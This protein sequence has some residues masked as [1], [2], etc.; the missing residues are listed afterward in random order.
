MTDLEKVAQ[1]AADRAVRGH[2]E[3]V[4]EAVEAGI[5]NSLT[6]LGL[7]AAHPMESQRDM[8]FLRATRKAAGSVKSKALLTAVGIAVAGF[9]ALLLHKLTTL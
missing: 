6:K 1:A 2:R 9:V 3:A 4:V 8:Q 7:D 5:E